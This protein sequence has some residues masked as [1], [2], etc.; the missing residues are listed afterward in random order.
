MLETECLLFLSFLCSAVLKLLDQTGYTRTG[1]PVTDLHA[2]VQSEGDCH[3]SSAQGQDPS[4]PEE[5]S[6]S[7][8][9]LV[10]PPHAH[11]S[12]VLFHTGVWSNSSIAPPVLVL[13]LL[14]EG[15]GRVGISLNQGF[16]PKDSSSLSC[17]E[18]VSHLIGAAAKWPLLCS[19][20][21]WAVAFRACL[22][23][24]NVAV[25]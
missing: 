7:P 16:P 17:R 11:L 6:V 12:S 21:G 10:L 8:F 19:A 1:E 20:A 23:L 4:A 5:L 9:L 3:H 22:C 13:A 15:Q 2:C 25:L 14:R 18:Q 24:G